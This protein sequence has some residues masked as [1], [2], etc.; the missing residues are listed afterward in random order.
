MFTGE[1]MLEMSFYFLTVKNA[2]EHFTTQTSRAALPKL[3][4]AGM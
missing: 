3:E 1:A 4:E 2:I